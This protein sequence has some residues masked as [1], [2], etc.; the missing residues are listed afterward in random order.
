MGAPFLVEGTPKGKH[1]VFFVSPPQKKSHTLLSSPNGCF[2]LNGEP[3]NHHSGLEAAP[4]RNGFHSVLTQASRVSRCFSSF[5]FRNSRQVFGSPLLA[6][7]SQLFEFGLLVYHVQ[8]QDCSLLAI[9]PWGLEK[10]GLKCVAS[11]R[12]PCEVWLLFG[13]QPDPIDRQ[14]R[15]EFLHVKLQRSKIRSQITTNRV[16][17]IKTKLGLTVPH[18]PILVI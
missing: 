9:M 7:G 11:Y 8:E 13:T 1:P 18:N 10:V 4:Q 14:Q 15:D 3:L 2:P 16:L 5:F 12:P 6:S 17:M